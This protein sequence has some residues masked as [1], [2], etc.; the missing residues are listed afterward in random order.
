MYTY[1]I[2]TRVE[3]TIADAWILWQQKVHIPSC[4]QTGSVAGYQFHKLLG[5]DEEDIQLF[6]LQLQIPSESD[7]QT[8]TSMHEPDLKLLSEK[9]WG[10]SV[11]EFRSLL[12]NID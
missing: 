6:V 12:Q 5:H 11:L 10:D 9:K 8:F 7:L 3:N 1:N 4:L 2:T